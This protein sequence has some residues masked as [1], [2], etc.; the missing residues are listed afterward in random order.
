MNRIKVLP[1][2]PRFPTTFWGFQYALPYI[3]KKSSM[4]PTGLATVIAD[5]LL[6]EDKFEAQRIIDLNVEPLTDEQLDNAELIFISSMLIQEP[7]HNEVVSRAHSRGKRVVSGGPFP[8]SYPE[9][10][11]GADF[12]VGGEAEATLPVF[13]EDF[14]RGEAQRVYTEESVRGR[15]LAALT[16]TGKV[17]VTQTPIPRWDLL[18]L[19]D[20]SSAAIQYSRGCPFNCE[21][22]DITKLFGREPRTKTPAQMVSEL[23]ALYNSGHRDS[24]FIV[25]DNFIGNR[26]NVKKLLPVVADWQRQRSFPFQLFTEAS[27]DL[28]W[29]INKEILDGMADAGFDAVFLGIESTDP[30]VLKAMKKG[31]NTKLSQLES[32]RRIQKAGIEVMGGFIIGSDGEKVEA[33]ERLFEFIQEA[34]IPIAMP[35]LLTAIRGTDLYERLNGEGRIRG[36][37]KGN[38]THFLG[39]N[40]DPKQDERTLLEGYKSLISRLFN[41]KNYY[42][43]CRTLQEHK[44][45][46]YQHDRT[47]PEGIMAFVKSL[48]QLFGRGGL[49]YARHV[50]GTAVTTPKRFPEAVAQAIKLDHFEKITNATLEADAYTPKVESLAERFR[51]KAERIYANTKKDIEKRIKIISAQGEKVLARAEK[52][53]HELHLDF[54]SRAEQ[55]FYRLNENINSIINNYRKHRT[56][57]II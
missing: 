32:V 2:Y 57:S 3:G 55:T 1:V 21:F 36:D 30:N 19:K 7:S 16:K 23:N 17:T 31:Q 10:T 8:T 11:N 38:N 6:P 33:P 37:S 47:S 4:P 27:M 25:D 41:P 48:K 45:P 9:R 53:Y 12:L 20:Y 35:G 18:N 52:K 28:A 24:V 26:A 13:L 49:E 34:G 50:F 42:A 22:C 39:F 5:P 15:S 14:V 29:D 44:E 43:R 40:F 56:P 54:R 46:R 51:E